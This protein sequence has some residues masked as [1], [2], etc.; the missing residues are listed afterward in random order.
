MFVHGWRLETYGD[1]DDRLKNGTRKYPR[2]GYW[3]NL[4]KV[5][6]R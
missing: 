3:E 6:G 5:K 1:A 4:D 2:K